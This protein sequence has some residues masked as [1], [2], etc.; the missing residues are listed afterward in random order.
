[1]KPFTQNKHK[2]TICRVQKSISL[3]RGKEVVDKW[4]K[5]VRKF[6]IVLLVLFAI[7]IVLN[8]WTNYEKAKL[9][10]RYERMIE[11]QEER[12]NELDGLIKRFHDLADRS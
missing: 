8:F 2:S 7:V 5:Y 3:S 4:E 1:V 6:N 11:L 12:G 9:N 10:Q